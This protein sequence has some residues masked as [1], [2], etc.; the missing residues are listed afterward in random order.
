MR[1]SRVSFIVTVM[2]LSVLMVFEGTL[3]LGAEPADLEKEVFETDFSDDIVGQPPSGWSSVW[4]DGDWEVLDDPRRLRLV[5]ESAGS[6]RGLSPN[7]VGDNG[8]IE[9]GVTVSTLVRGE[10]VSHYQFYLGL[11]LSGEPRSENGYLLFVRPPHASD[12]NHVSIGRYQEGSFTTL[13]SARLPFELDGDT[14]YRMRF[15]REGSTLRG[16]IWRDG[17]DE[18]PENWQVSVDDGVA[19]F[20]ECTPMCYNTGWRD[21]YGIFGHAG[22]FTRSLRYFR[23]DQ[24]FGISVPLLREET[25][26]GTRRIRT[27]THS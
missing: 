15:E 19:L 8:H 10:S 22:N 5:I 18:E 21:A 3:V 12:A 25:H 26:H 9:G 11:H 14:W 23:H 4:R 1:G 2:V 20:S 24:Q 6:R 17:T 7:A 16:K 13:A 27:K